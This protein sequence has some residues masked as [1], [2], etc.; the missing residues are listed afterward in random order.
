[1]GECN[2]AIDQERKGLN[3][4]MSLPEKDRINLEDFTAQINRFFLQTV[5]TARSS[6]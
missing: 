4:A 1:M 5:W 3:K 6:I 2:K